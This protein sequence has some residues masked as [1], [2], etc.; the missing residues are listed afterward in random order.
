M[1]HRFNRWFWVQLVLFQS[2]WLISVIGQNDWILIAATILILHMVF[3]P[4]LRQDLRIIPLAL[5][6]ITID[7]ILTLSGV[8]SFSTFPYWL[9][10]L[11]L[12][13]T[14]SLGHSLEWLKNIPVAVLI[15]LGAIMGSASYLSGWK[16]EAV[17]MPLGATST[18]ILLALVW[19]FL[20]PIM[21]KLDTRLRRVR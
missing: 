14:L 1:N 11:W 9:V 18:A 21:L 16:L 20:L 7:A 13:F 3:T 12:G 10:F 15:P 6:G 19:A 8:F 5:I 2:L 4:G 17:E